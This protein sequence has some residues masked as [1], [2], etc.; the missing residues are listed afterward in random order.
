MNRKNNLVRDVTRAFALV[1]LIT[2]IVLF[3]LFFG[4]AL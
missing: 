2:Y 3:A 4:G 1:V